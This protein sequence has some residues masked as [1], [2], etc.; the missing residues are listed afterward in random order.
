MNRLLEAMIAGVILFV[1][2]GVLAAYSNYY[3]TTSYNYNLPSCY[4]LYP[5]H[6]NNVT[7][8]YVYPPAYISC[9][10][11][12]T[13]TQNNAQLY[14]QVLSVPGYALVFVGGVTFIIGAALFL[15]AIYK[16]RHEHMKEVRRR[17]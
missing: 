13:T 2:G 1:I 7:G 3:N 5:Y 16:D 9:E 10:K 6:Y 14:S 12:V 4:S 17:R 15:V 8:Q 11:N